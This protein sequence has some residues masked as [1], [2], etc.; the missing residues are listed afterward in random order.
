MLMAAKGG[1]VKKMGRFGR[2]VG[3]AP[4]QASGGRQRC[5]G[6]RE[7]T[8]QLWHLA[9]AISAA[10]T[11]APA[12]AQDYPAKPVPIVVPYAPAAR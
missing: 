11:P 8:I 5:N 6:V 12:A 4:V 3:L 10:V 7:E 2:R 1:T 9:L